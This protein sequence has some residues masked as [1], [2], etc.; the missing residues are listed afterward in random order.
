MGGSLSSIEANTGNTFQIELNSS[1]KKR[2]TFLYG[3]NNVEEVKRMKPTMIDRRKVTVKAQLF[4]INYDEKSC[5]FFLQMFLSFSSRS[6]FSFLE[7]GRV[8]V[9]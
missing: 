5:S 6:L 2:Q 1:L 3:R 4:Q 8:R 9:C 7:F